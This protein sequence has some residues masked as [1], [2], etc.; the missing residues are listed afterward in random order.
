MSTSVR[1]RYV[2]SYDVSSDARRSR[3]YTI[4]QGFGDHVQ[5][6]VFLADLADRELVI[7]RTRLRDVINE[8]EDQVLFV[9]LGR[10][11][12]PLDECLEVLGKPYSPPVR[13]NIV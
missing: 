11:T 3:V 8:K 2:V 10:E 13:S 7:L 1:R 4:L 5:F 12:R 9:D 6:S